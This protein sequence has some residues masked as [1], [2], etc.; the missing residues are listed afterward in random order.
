MDD[1]KPVLDLKLIQEK[2]SEYAMKGALESIRDF[3]SGYNSPYRKAIEDNLNG[4]TVEG[5]EI[6]DI[7][8][9]LNDSISKE[10]DMIA[11]TAIAKTYIPKIK[12]MLV[13]APSEIKFSEI[14]KEFIE[15]EYGSYY[16]N[17]ID[18]NDYSCFLEKHDEYGWYNVKVESH[19]SEYEFVLHEMGKYDDETK[20]AKKDGTYKPRYSILSLP[21]GKTPRTYGS[22]YSSKM[23]ITLEDGVSIEMPFNKDILSDNF[24]T[25]LARYVISKTSIEIDVRDF[26][27]DM[28]PENDCHC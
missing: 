26:D 1:I 24:M 11:N 7:I 13:R 8:A 25:I 9:I 17:D 3:Y 21:S 4:K 19:S 20:K 23:K 10:V 2:A 28:F 5:I 18:F 12:N 22:G 16:D 6:P 27:E 15:E 14:L